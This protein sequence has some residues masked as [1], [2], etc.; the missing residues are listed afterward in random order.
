MKFSVAICTWNRAS[1]L[2]RTLQSLAQVRVPADCEWEVVVVENNCTDQTSEVCGRWTSRLPLKT[3]HESQQGHCYARNR[4]IKN[5]H[6]DV[7]VWTDDDVE[8]SRDWLVAYQT[9]VVS[10]ASI[11]FW[12]GPI[13]PKFSEKV[14]RW[15]TENWQS[16][17]GCFATRDLGKSPLEF[18]EERLPYGANFAIRT[19]VQK[20][21]PFDVRL[22]RR[23]TE[24]SGDD[25]IEM[26]RRVLRAGYRGRWVPA[27]TV[28]HVIPH[29]RATLNYVY[30]YFVGQ[31]KR[32]S[33]SDAAHTGGTSTKP[34]LDSLRHKLLFGLKYPIT[35]SPNWMSHWIRSALAQGKYEAQ[36][37]SGRPKTTLGA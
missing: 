14:P 36:Q 10:D 21:F 30:R 25:E 11:A 20:Q 37:D 2:D 19:E 15:I 1:S 9:A 6:S 27:A 33:R 5:C 28:D 4:A 8:V 3:F 12:G 7:I 35:S 13:R 17:Q 32:I 31:G 16:L 26:L 23:A 18:T 34:R 29:N 24:V 22:G